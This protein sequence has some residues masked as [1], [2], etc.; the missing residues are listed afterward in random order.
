[1]VTRYIQACYLATV[2]RTLLQHI[3][4][5]IEILPANAICKECNKVFNFIENKGQCPS[6]EGK[7]LDILCGKEFMIKEIVAC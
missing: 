4:L 1:M 5:E 7:N 2:D 6:C 3:K